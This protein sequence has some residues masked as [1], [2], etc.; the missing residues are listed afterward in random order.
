MVGVGARVL[1]DM[2]LMS[3]RVADAFPPSD[4]RLVTPRPSGEPHGRALGRRYEQQAVVAAGVSV[5]ESTLPRSDGQ[6][7]HWSTVISPTLKSNGCTRNCSSSLR[8]RGGAHRLPIVS[9]PDKSDDTTIPTGPLRGLAAAALA[10]AGTA[11]ALLALVEAWQVLRATFSTHPRAGRS[12]S[13][14][15]S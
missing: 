4:A 2:L 7:S 13:P 10:I 14:C 12:P 6:R 1:A 15:C 9:H 11:L 5:N 3:K 8:R